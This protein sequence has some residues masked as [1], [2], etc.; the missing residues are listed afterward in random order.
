MALNT[1]KAKDDE[2]GQLYPMGGRQK[3]LEKKDY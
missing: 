3:A 1:S 2:N